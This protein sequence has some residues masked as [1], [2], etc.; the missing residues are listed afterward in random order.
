M[1][2]V[3]VKR[4]GNPS[5][6]VRNSMIFSPSKDISKKEI[7]ERP[8][9]AYDCIICLNLG[10]NIKIN[11]FVGFINMVCIEKPHT[12]EDF[13][14]INRILEKYKHLKYNKQLNKLEGYENYE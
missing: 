4:E 9:H 14:D 7:L 1:Y 6:I 2:K 8:G 5:Y 12:R 3:T 10:N 11:S 13:N